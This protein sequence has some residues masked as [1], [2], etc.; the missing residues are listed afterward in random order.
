MLI[1]ALKNMNKTIL[2]ILVVIIVA[3]GGYFLLKDNY[4]SPTSNQDNNQGTSSSQDQSSVAAG[5]EK[6]SIKNFSFS[7]SDITI[8]KGTKV[9][10]TNDD[11]VEH[12][13]TSQDK[14]DSG[15]LAKGQSFSR[16]FDQAGIFEYRC[17]P[18]ASMKG[19]IIVTD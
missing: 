12:T 2:I 14:F 8:K 9:T 1:N 3:V 15:L 11:Q 18:H 7:P 4:K 10:W 13:V 6:I 17:T 19:K 16:I 5:E